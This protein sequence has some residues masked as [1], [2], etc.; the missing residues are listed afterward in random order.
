MVWGTKFLADNSIFMVQKCE[1][2]WRKSSVVVVL[3]E[4]GREEGR[5]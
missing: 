5:R 3:V 2:Q 1:R 4:G